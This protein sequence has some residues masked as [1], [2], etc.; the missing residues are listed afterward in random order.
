MAQEGDVEF[1]DGRVV[2]GVINTSTEWDTNAIN[3]LSCDIYW[4]NGEAL[5]ADEYNE[6]VGGM[7][8]HEFVTDALLMTE[9]F[10][11]DDF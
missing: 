11:E 9:P 1:P 10:Y 4:K 2:Y 3:I 5:T 6:D 8:L 7:F